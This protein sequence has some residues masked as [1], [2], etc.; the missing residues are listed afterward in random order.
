MDDE[1]EIVKSRPALTD[2][3][4]TTVTRLSQIISDNLAQAL[5]NNRMFW[6]SQLDTS[7]TFI[8]REQLEKA[9]EM[10]KNTSPAPPCGSVDNPHILSPRGHR[11]VLDGGWAF[12]QQ[13]GFTVGFHKD[14][15]RG[16]GDSMSLG[17][18]QVIQDTNNQ[19]GT[20]PNG[21]A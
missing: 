7:A 16:P 11:K 1:T 10:V 14:R 9:I 18:K 5:D 20:Q 15:A 4:P 17:H 12:C 3:E 2:T 21:S 6:K 8:T 13:C 19:E